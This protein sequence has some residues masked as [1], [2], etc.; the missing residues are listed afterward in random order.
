MLLI[1]L[2]MLGVIKRR[3]FMRTH[4]NS[5]ANFILNKK[6]LKKVPFCLLYTLSLK[7][8]YNRNLIHSQIF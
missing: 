8:S 1:V 2:E 4:G 3:H 7:K 5:T 6:P